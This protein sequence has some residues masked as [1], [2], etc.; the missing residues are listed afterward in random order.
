MHEDKTSANAGGYW[1]GGPHSI[2]EIQIFIQIT[3]ICYIPH[4][5]VTKEPPSQISYVN[6]C[7]SFIAIIYHFGSHFY[8]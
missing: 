5:F 8:K 6:V 4:S 1:L 3:E 2:Q 7:I